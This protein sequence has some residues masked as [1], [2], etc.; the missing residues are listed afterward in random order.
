M[1][2]AELTLE[3]W[4][5]TDGIGRREL[6]TEGEWIRYKK[7][8]VNIP[9]SSRIVTTRRG[10]AYWEGT[11]DC[12]NLSQQYRQ[13]LKTIYGDEPNNRQRAEAMLITMRMNT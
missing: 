5:A 11:I 3:L 7:S 4:M 8:G 13:I 2:D 1:T 6:S 12:M 10:I 9:C